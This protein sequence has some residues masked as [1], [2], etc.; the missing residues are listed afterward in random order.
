LPLQK[1]SSSK[2]KKEVTLKFFTVPIT[3]VSGVRAHRHSRLD[4]DSCD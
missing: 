4:L 3:P 1:T 2:L